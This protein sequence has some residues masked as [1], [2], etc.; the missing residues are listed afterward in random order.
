MGL[1]I[2]GPLVVFR[3]CRG[4]GVPEVWSL[5]LSGLPPAIGVLFD[6]WRWR[7]LEMV[8]AVVLAGIAVSVVLALVT[9]DPQ[10]VLLESAILTGLFGL[11]CLVSLRWR[12]P[13]IFSFAQ[14]F[15]GGRHSADGVE[16]DEDYEAY[17]EA[18]F[19][20]RA[21]TAVWGAV[22]LVESVVKA[23]VVTH[24]STERALLFNRTVPWVVY[25]ALMAWTMWWG[26]RLRRTKPAP[27]TR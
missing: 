5:V 15:Y 27:S 7:T 11:G 17:A 20:W 19:Y 25:A 8:G 13:L 21:V 14:A 3:V 9:D 10:V 24:T 2:V 16:F 22:Y 4:G 26:F 6:W 12:R 1:D 23:I 18:R